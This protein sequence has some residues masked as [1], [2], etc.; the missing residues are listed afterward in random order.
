MTF[1]QSVPQHA[2]QI[3]GGV[4][5]LFLLLLLA[6]KNDRKWVFICFTIFGASCG[7]AYAAFRE[8]GPFAEIAFATALLI[9][10]IAT[11]S[12]LG[13]LI[14]RAILPAIGFTP[15]RILQDVSVAMIH[16]AWGIFCLQAYGVSVAGILTTSAVLTA[17]I[18]FSMQD[19]LGNILAGLAIQTDHSIRVGDFIMLDNTF[20]CVVETR[21]RYT[22]I[23]TPNWETMIIPNSVLMKN[24]FSV[25]G[26]R[27][28]EPVQWR[29][30][31]Y[32]NVDYK[33]SPAKVIEVVEK[34]LRSA[35]ILYVAKNPPIHCLFIDYSDSFA[36]YAVRYW[37]TNLFI[38]SPTDSEIRVHLYAALQRAGINLATPTQS[39]L[40]TQDTMERRARKSEEAEQE[41]VIELHKLELFRSLHDKE[42]HRLAQHLKPAPFVKGDIVTRQGSKAHHLYI[43]ASGH[44]D[45]IVEGADHQST[46]VAD[47]GPGQFF[48]EIGLL[49]GEPRVATVIATTPVQTYR[50]DKDALEGVMK[51]R[52]AIAEE[53]SHAL[54]QRQTE[55]NTIL[56]S[57]DSES[58]TRRLAKDQSDILGKIKNFFSLE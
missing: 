21:W 42:L 18:G 49:T 56:H 26:R 1:L 11:L 25:L 38:E 36:K 6:A 20:G 48:G 16:L 27:I 8:T 44:V 57:L 58:K 17:V 43:I 9:A 35:E 34:G 19:T 15:P 33:H 2:I 45:V 53:L 13:T 30:W 39:V 47:L 51:E 32:F 22:A 55:L 4:G 3:I 37:C 23:Q 40:L 31:I 54:A 12:M 14:F 29:R 24:K 50:L 7:I 5:A 41:R 52:P 10:G 28:G 46:K